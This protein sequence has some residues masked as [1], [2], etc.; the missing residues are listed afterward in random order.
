MN[1]WQRSFL[2]KLET[3]R[4]QWLHKFEDFAAEHIEPAFCEFDQ[5]ATTNGF[6]VSAPQCQPGTRLFKFGLTENG[7]TMITFHMHGLEKVEECAEVYVPGPE[8]VGPVYSQ[9]I[10]GEADE[11]WVRRQFEQALERFI[12]A[13][14]AAGQPAPGPLGLAPFPARV[15]MSPSLAPRPR[16]SVFRPLDRRHARHQCF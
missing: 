6:T 7:Y 15:L 12:V 16:S 11:R 14:G 2:P 9:S 4:K 13:F 3:A 5:F 1:D 10:L 8:E